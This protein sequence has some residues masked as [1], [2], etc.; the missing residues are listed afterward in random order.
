VLVRCV[1]KRKLVGASLTFEG[2]RPV[3]CVVGMFI[4]S[5]FGTKGTVAF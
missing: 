3:S 5:A 4:T 1:L 2:R